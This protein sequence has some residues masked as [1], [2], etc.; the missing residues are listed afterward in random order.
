MVIIGSL[1]CIL[2]VQTAFKSA[3]RRSAKRFML[4]CCYARSL[5]TEIRTIVQFSHYTPI[6]TYVA[7]THLRHQ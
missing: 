5:F 6:K 1:I 7:Q 3:Q 2:Q 4:S